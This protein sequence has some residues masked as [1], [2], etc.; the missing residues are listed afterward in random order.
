MP[1]FLDRAKAHLE[2]GLFFDPPHDRCFRPD[3]QDPIKALKGLGLHEMDFAWWD[4]ARRTMHLLEV[5]DY[6]RP[7]AK[8]EQG[9]LVNECVQKA[10]DSI[11]LFASIW[12]GLP[13]AA[14]LRAW[15]PEE[16]HEKPR[17]PS[18]LSLFFVFKIPEPPD[19]GPQSQS[20]AW[21]TLEA[22]ARNRLKARRE[23]FQLSAIAE[24]FL[25]DHRAASSRGLPLKTAEALLG[26]SRKPKRR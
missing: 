14:R 7:A 10:T 24:V 17:E 22:N 23:L 15:V 19:R 1:S 2:S 11:L 8:L 4:P 9:P 6:S 18:S 3:Q 21:T 26:P 20:I 12:Y 25:M 13:Y 16:W 5:K